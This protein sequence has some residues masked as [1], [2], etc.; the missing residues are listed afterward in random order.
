MSCTYIDPVAVERAVSGDLSGAVLTLDER[1]AAIVELHARGHCD[2]VIAERV[3]LATET[4]RRNRNKLNLPANVDNN[5]ER[6]WRH[7]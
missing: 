4:V 1:R 6:I 7:G 5:G 3:G 2:S